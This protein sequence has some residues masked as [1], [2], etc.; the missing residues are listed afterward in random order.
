MIHIDS[1]NRDFQTF[2]NSSEFEVPVNVKPTES[3]TRY[4]KRLSTMI[5]YT[6]Q[7]VGNSE[8]N[9][10]ISKIKNDTFLT[11]IIPISASKCIIVAGND[12]VEQLI[13]QPNYFVNIKVWFDYSNKFS[14]V[15]H[16]DHLT[17][18]ASMSSDIFQYYFE[19]INYNDF[20]EKK[21]N[22]FYRNAYFV[23]TTRHFGN[24]ITILGL[25]KNFSSGMILENVSK[26][27]KSKLIRYGNEFYFEKEDVSLDMLDIFIV[28]PSIPMERLLSLDFVMESPYSFQT[29]DFVDSNTNVL[30]I[31]DIFEHST[32]YLPISGVDNDIVSLSYNLNLLPNFDKEHYVVAIVPYQNIFPSLLIDKNVYRSNIFLS[33][34]YLSIPNKILL[35]LYG[36]RRLENIPYITLKINKDLVMTNMVS[37]IPQMESTF[38]CYTENTTKNDFVIFRSEQVIRLKEIFR[39]S[40]DVSILL[41]TNQPITFE[42][43]DFQTMTNGQNILIQDFK[44]VISIVFRL[45]K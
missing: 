37:N 21:L 45:N 17:K 7:W 26:R 25:D 38:V 39:H 33:L 28:Y 11:K 18:I 6:F 36:T 10:P 2:L 4:Q 9:N 1:T 44:N 22:E 31:V 41:P 27:W 43:S 35:N 42:Q 32:I 5:E 30:S 34:D 12:Y 20:K 3:D 23:N 8:E 13:N 14:T 24:N 16:Y 19:N 29:S 15:Q 40:L